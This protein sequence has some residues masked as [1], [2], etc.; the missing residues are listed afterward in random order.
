MLAVQMSLILNILTYKFFHPSQVERNM[1]SIEDNIIEHKSR[2]LIDIFYF[3]LML[4][5]SSPHR[6]QSLLSPFKY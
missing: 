2:S 5:F 3:Y 6:K 1:N 4:F